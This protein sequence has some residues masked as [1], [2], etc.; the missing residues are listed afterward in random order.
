[1]EE[2]L[3]VISSAPHIE[4]EETIPKI[5]QTVVLALIPAMICAVIFFGFQAIL[6]LATCVITCVV[7]EYVFQRARKQEVT[8][9]DWSA[10][11]T[12]ILL[13]LILPPNL[14]MLSAALGSV[15]AIG[16]GKQ[17]FGGLGYNIFNPA[18]VGRAFL[19]ATYPVAMAT[20]IKPFFYIGSPDAI[21]TAT[22]LA[23]VNEAQKIASWTVDWKLLI[24]Y[25]GGCLGETSAIAILLGGAYLLYK[26]CVEW[27][28]PAAYL[29]TVFVLGSILW[30]VDSNKYP[31]PIFHLLAGGL[32]LG[33]I[34]MATDMITSPVTPLGCWLF[35]IG[36]GILVIIIRL[37]GGAAE[38]VMYS[39]LLM[40]AVTPLLN[41]YTKP[42]VFGQQK[43]VEA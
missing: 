43:G 26:N 34:F 7:T 15:V 23:L 17:V 18:L 4:S 10:V 20:W 9:N 3:F 25:I 5:M 27:R 39:I 6:L 12:G 42:R 31:D 1:M 33:A 13:A 41:R 37:P 30:I 22:P 29:G 40:N 16:I 21:T 24:G 2:Q 36:A 32:M 19:Q 35:G 38:G 11:I 14:S 8:L 28:I